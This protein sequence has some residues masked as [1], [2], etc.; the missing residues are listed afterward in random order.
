MFLFFIKYMLMH[1]RKRQPSSQTSLSH[2]SILFFL[3][4]MTRKMTRNKKALKIKAFRVQ[5]KGLKPLST[6]FQRLSAF[7]PIVSPISPLF[8]LFSRTTSSFSKSSHLFSIQDLLSRL[9]YLIH[10][11]KFPFL[12]LIII[13]LIELHT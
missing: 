4:K 1:S 7:S 2:T 3:K 12:S 5:K 9:E 13:Q 10:L 11:V 8:N 6:V